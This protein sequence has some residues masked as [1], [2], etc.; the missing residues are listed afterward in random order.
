MK[1]IF[2][3]GDSIMDFDVF[4]IK[5]AETM[6]YYQRIEHDIKMI[7]SCMHEGDMDENFE[8]IEKMTLGQ[9]IIELKELDNFDNEPLISAEDYA[10]LERICGNRNRWA[11]E[12]FVNFMYEDDCFNSKEYRIEC[13][14]L[15]KDRDIVKIASDIL[16]K[17]RID[18][19]TTAR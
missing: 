12:T 5:Y 7:Y 6:L 18:Y 16:E 15:A 10:I 13:A 4:K 17:I 1:K 9:M 2:K 11:H 8:E 14:K 19:C 3:N